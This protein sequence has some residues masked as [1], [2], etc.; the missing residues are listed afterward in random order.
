MYERLSGKDMIVYDVDGDEHESSHSRTWRSSQAH[1]RE[2]MMA[3][4]NKAILVGNV[5]HEPELRYSRADTPVATLRVATQ[6]REGGNSEPKTQWHSVVVFRKMAQNCCRYLSKGSQV[7]VEGR[8]QTRKWQD[9][10]GNERYSTEVVA[11]TVQFL[12]SWWREEDE[13][14]EEDSMESE[15]EV[16]G[17]TESEVGNEGGFYFGPP[18]PNDEVLF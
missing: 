1:T 17:D 12:G 2:M 14:E 3:S 4:V 9:R 18:A 8:L 15:P 13:D 7:Y 10:E 11:N 5:G 16:R 6:S